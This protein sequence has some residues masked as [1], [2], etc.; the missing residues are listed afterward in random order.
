MPPRWPCDRLWSC[1]DFLGFD[2]AWITSS[3]QALTALWASRAGLSE[4]ELLAIAGLAPVQWAPVDL[5][6][7]EALGSASGGFGRVELANSLVLNPA[8][9]MVFAGLGLIQRWI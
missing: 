9:P 6:L 1:F 4:T 3:R 7:E 2:G 5:A 8:P